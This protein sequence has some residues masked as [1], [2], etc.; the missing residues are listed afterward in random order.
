MRVTLASFVLGITILSS[1]AA[2]AEPNFELFPDVGG[3]NSGTARYGATVL[4]YKT[5]NLYGCQAAFPVG[6]AKPA[7]LS[8]VTTYKFSLMTG[9][10]VKTQPNFGVPL[11]NPTHPPNSAFWQ[12]NQSTGKIQ[13]CTAF[14]NPTCVTYTISE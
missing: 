11:M 8:C 12:I 1:F 14:I 2:R 10:D 13:F 5:G 6:P 9:A 4:S 7:A 3:P